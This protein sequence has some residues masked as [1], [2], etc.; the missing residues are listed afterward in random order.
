LYDISGV[1][2][3]FRQEFPIKVPRKINPSKYHPEEKEKEKERPKGKEKE[4]K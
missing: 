4:K 3:D 2:V 1:L